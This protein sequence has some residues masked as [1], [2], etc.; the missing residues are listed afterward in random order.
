V[1]ESPVLTATEGRTGWIR[2]NRPE[3]M[4]AVTVDLAV[5]LEAALAHLAGDSAA[6]GIAAF[7]SRRD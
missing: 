2:L 7:T 3:A 6:E 1:T 5:A 4:N